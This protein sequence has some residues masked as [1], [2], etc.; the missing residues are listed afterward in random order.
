MGEHMVER[1]RIGMVGPVISWFVVLLASVGAYG[2]GAVSGEEAVEIVAGPM[3]T[4]VGDGQVFLWIQTNI[5]AGLLI[6]L[7]S[8]EKG[9]AKTYGLT[10][11]ALGGHIRTVRIRLSP[12]LVMVA[13]SG[14]A[15]LSQA[16]ARDGASAIQSPSARRT[17]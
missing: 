13:S 9:E 1:M 15:I 17:R 4:P 14:R 12:G 5:P 2:A 10:T 16:S 7:S 11:T 6:E 3:F 8:V